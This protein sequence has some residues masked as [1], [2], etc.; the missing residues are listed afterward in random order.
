MGSGWIF[1]SAFEPDDPDSGCFMGISFGFIVGWVLHAIF[2]FFPDL[3]SYLVFAW[4][5]LGII[6][7]VR[8]R[9]KVAP[10]RLSPEERS[11]Y[12]TSLANIEQHFP[13]K[14]KY[15]IAQSTVKIILMDGQ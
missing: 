15:E 10:V 9:L 2:L 14:Q 12:N 6:L 7:A 8:Y 3:F 1:G 13:D 5:V 11:A 4:P